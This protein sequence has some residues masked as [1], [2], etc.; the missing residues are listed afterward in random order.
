MGHDR[1]RRLPSQLPVR[2]VLD[3]ELVV[4]DEEGKP[5]FPLVCE[6]VLHHPTDI[7]E[8][9]APDLT[10]SRRAPALSAGEIEGDCLGLRSTPLSFSLGDETCRGRFANLCHRWAADDHR[11]PTPLSQEVLAAQT[12]V[13]SGGRHG[14]TSGRGASLAISSPV[15]ENET[16][17]RPETIT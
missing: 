17:L 3:G 15:T 14:A 16:P 2:A 6:C 11:K 7:G 9:N 12:S 13:T 4:L 1:P 8:E 10:R 5:D